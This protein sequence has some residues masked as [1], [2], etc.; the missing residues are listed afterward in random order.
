MKYLVLFLF[1]LLAVA[2]VSAYQC[3]RYQCAPG[4]SCICDAGVFRC[5]YRCEELTIIQTVTN[6]WV[7]GEQHPSVQVSVEIINH[8]SRT[9][10]DI[11][12]ATDVSLNSN[13]M[14]GVEKCELIEG[15]TLID[16]PSYVEIA[17][18]K[19]HTFGYI[20]KGNT[21]AHLWPQRVYIM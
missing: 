17:P 2:N 4:H 21:S 13:Q 9:V 12:I 20:A 7:D 11:I 6:H 14:W 19:S 3:G 16:L 8:T 15:L 10:K 1:A 5:V 18:G